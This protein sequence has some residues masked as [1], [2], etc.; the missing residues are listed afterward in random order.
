MDYLPGGNLRKILNQNGT[1]TEEDAQFYVAEILI[2]LDIIHE[3][4]F[5]HRDLKVPFF[6]LVFVLNENF[7]MQLD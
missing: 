5:I 7:M 4:G 2:A 1:F 3:S 6:F